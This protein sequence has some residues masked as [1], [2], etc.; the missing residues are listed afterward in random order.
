[1]TTTVT[2]T[3]LYL[4]LHTSLDKYPPSVLAILSTI[5]FAFLPQINTEPQFRASQLATDPPP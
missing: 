5:L 2:A 1:L 4:A 3:I